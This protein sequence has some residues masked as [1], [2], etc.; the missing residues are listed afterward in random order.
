[1]FETSE[2]GDRLNLHD[3]IF[4]MLLKNYDNYT[5]NNLKFDF[6]DVFSYN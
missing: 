1:M 2:S 5:L 6:K 3:S 4:L